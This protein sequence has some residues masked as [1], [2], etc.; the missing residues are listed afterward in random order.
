MK[1]AAMN[2]MVPM[3]ERAPMV[4]RSAERMVMRMRETAMSAR[5]A[6]S[7]AERSALCE[8]FDGLRRSLDGVSVVAQHIHE[9]GGGVTVNAAT[10]Q[11]ASVQMAFAR[12]VILSQDDPA[13][14]WDQLVKITGFGETQG[15][16]QHIGTPD[17]GA[18][19]LIRRHEIGV[20]MLPQLAG[21]LGK[22]FMNYATWFFYYRAPG[23]L[24]YRYADK[25]SPGWEGLSVVLTDG[26][27]V[28]WTG[29]GYL[30]RIER[31]L[32][33]ASA[34]LSALRGANQDDALPFH[35]RGAQSPGLPAGQGGRGQRLGPVPHA[36]GIVGDTF[37][38]GHGEVAP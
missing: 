18:D 13:A 17:P 34:A 24:S 35:H 9:A 32:D 23:N 11:A 10:L 28:G 7:E 30:D 2:S 3:L 20:D 4:L 36:M 5:L 29:A 31:S 16:F 6:T 22:F 33:E 19:K 37:A 1:Q 27:G 12:W 8:R 14:A 21:E 15:S 25:T 26:D 38:A